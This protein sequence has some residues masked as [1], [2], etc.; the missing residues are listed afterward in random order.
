MA[1]S[2]RFIHV[3]GGLETENVAKNK[4]LTNFDWIV[5]ARQLGQNSSSSTSPATSAFVGC[6]QSAMVK[7]Y[8]NCSKEEN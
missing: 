6:L 3:V 5:M 8:Q 1:T 7:A 2:E 4:D